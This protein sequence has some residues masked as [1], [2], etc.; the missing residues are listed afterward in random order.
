MQGAKGYVA[1]S[2]MDKS[3]A[4]TIWRLVATLGDSLGA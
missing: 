3:L 2:L 1:C 4:G